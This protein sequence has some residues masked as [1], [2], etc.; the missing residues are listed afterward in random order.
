[1]QKCGRQTLKPALA[2]RFLFIAFVSATVRA[3]AARLARTLSVT[4]VAAFAAPIEVPASAFSFAA[5][6]FHA[7]VAHLDLYPAVVE[8]NIRRVESKEIVNE[9]AFGL[10]EREAAFDVDVKHHALMKLYRFC[11]KFTKAVDVEAVEVTHVHKKPAG[12]VVSECAIHGSLADVEVRRVLVVFVE[13]VEFLAYKT[14][15][16]LFL[17]QVL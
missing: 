12:A 3:E 13:P 14:F 17:V 6:F 9:F 8:L 5:S 15:D 7:F 11:E 1:M 16:E 10:K 2:E 4:P